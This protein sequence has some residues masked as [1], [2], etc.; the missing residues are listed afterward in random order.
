MH[1]LLTK[2]HKDLL[3]LEALVVDGYLLARVFKNFNIDVEDKTKQRLTDETYKPHN[4]VIYAGDLHSKRYREFLKELGFE[5]IAIT[6]TDWRDK[7]ST[8]PYN[9]CISMEG[10]PQPF[11]EYHEKVNWLEDVSS[12]KRSRRSSSSK[13][14]PNKSSISKKSKNGW[15]KRKSRDGTRIYYANYIRKISQNERPD[16]YSS[17]KEHM[18]E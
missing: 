16:D 13:V 12:D 8:N 5:L 7:D 6:G 10:F 18:Q 15:E 14:F 1:D 9:N 2:I 17:D 4:I 3:E 11:F